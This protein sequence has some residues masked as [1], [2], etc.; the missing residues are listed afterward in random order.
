MYSAYK[1]G[2]WPQSERKSC[3]ILTSARD[4]IKSYPLSPETSGQPRCAPKREGPS[5]VVHLCVPAAAVFTNGRGPEVNRAQ[6]LGNSNCQCQVGELEKGFRRYACG[7]EDPRG[8]EIADF[9]GGCSKTNA[10]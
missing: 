2:K 1:S 4:H 10:S 9:I 6:R 3:D 8:K 7:E 5:T